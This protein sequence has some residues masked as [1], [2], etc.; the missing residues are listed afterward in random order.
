[1]D[2]VH[3]FRCQVR[4]RSKEGYWSGVRGV[5]VG[6]QDEDRAQQALGGVVVQP[7]ALVRQV[8][9]GQLVDADSFV[10][11]RDHLAQAGQVEGCEV[12]GAGRLPTVRVVAEYTL[13]A[14]TGGDPPG[15][16]TAYTGY[17][18]TPSRRIAT[19][20]VRAMSLATWRPCG[21]LP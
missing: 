17:W 20:C 3:P 8:G 11:V 21:A 19:T 10:G 2:V 12:V 6:I 13:C 4:V 16:G 7:L 14:A 18:T 15:A 1:M 9:R 5:G